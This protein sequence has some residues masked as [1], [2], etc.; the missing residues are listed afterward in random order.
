MNSRTLFRLTLIFASCLLPVGV[1]SA[2]ADSSHA[3][4]IRLSLVQGDVRF[5]RSTHGDPLADAQAGWEAAQANLPIA[6]GYVLA[7]DNGRAEVEFENGEM[8]FLNENTVLEFYDLSL[9]DGARTT[10]LILRQG[11]AVFHANPAGGDYLSVTGGDFTVEATTRATFRVN[12]F[13]DGSNVNVQ[14]GRIAVLRKKESTP[15]GKG[16]S[17]TMKAGDETSVSIGGEPIGDEFDKWVSGRMDDMIAAL[18]ASPQQQSNAPGFSDL[19]TYGNWYSCAGFGYGWRPFGVTSAWTPFTGGSWFAD[20]TFGWTYLSPAAWGWAPY[21]Y[22]GWAFD[23]SCGGWFYTPG[24]YGYPY[25]GYPGYGYPGI[26]RKHF[27]P[28]VHPPQPIYHPF[29]AV[30]VKQNGKIGIVP[31]HVLDQKGKPP[32]NIDHGVLAASSVKGLN[33]PLAS[34]DRGQKFETLK[35]VPH[36][37]LSGSLVAS[38]A[39]TRVSRTLLEGN[40]G[41]RIVSIGKDSSIVYDPAEHRFVN[42]SAPA[43]S[44]SAANA[45]TLRTENVQPGAVVPGRTVP[46]ARTNTL[47]TVRVPTAP[48]SGRVSTPPARTNFAPPPPPRSS[49]SSYGGGGGSSGSS[50]GSQWRGGSSG[51]SSSGSSASSSGSS[52]RGSSG[53]SGASASSGGRPH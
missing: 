47:A 19:Y 21:H 35:S 42:S 16:Q 43:S 6:Q 33:A 38:S 2:K 22:G 51:S 1:L 17:L 30:F 8:A 49:G 28:R 53:S 15:L 45:G 41:S 31:M 23:A 14:S 25:Y 48:T 44:A 50:G 32:I 13:D 7:T 18:N 24:V 37:A 3:R 5:A 9:K 36:D 39:P 52:S 26:N 27:P 20:P 4:I 34:L 29:T 11:S 12:N 40:S 10:R 46:S